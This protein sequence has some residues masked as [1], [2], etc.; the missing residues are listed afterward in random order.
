MKA[1]SK[2][3]TMMMGNIHHRRAL[4]NEN[5]S[6]A[7]LTLRAAVLRNFIYPPDSLLIGFGAQFERLHTISSHLMQHRS[8]VKQ[9]VVPTKQKRSQPKTGL[10]A[11]SKV[12]GKNSLSRGQ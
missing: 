6:P 11:N 3:S 1:P 9:L 2:K 4:K 10:Q 5:S 8:K 12:A 7:T